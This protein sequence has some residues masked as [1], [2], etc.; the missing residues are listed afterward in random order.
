MKIRFAARR[1]S[2]PVPR[3]KNALLDGSCWRIPVSAATLEGFRA[4]VKSDD[5]PEHV[6]VTFV[7]REIYL[8]MSG[9]EIET[10]VKV[11]AE[12]RLEVRPV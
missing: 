12:Y 3:P 2:P 6:R 11:K 7:D 10:H 4:W 5:F 9:E 8:D 1:T